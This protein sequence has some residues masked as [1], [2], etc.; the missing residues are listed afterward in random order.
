MGRIVPGRGLRPEYRGLPKGGIARL[1][2]ETGVDVKLPP[3]EVLEVCYTGDTCA[4]GIALSPP[5]SSK[6]ANDDDDDSRRASLLRRAFL[7]PLVLCECTYLENNEINDEDARGHMRLADVETVLRSHGWGDDHDHEDQ[8]IVLFH[9]SARWSP[10]VRTLDAIAAG[11]PRD[12]RERTEVS[13]ASLLSSSSS[14]DEEKDGTQT[15]GSIA[16]RLTKENGC[17]SVAEY[18]RELERNRLS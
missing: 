8:T 15:K 7:A 5:P 4:E 17:V 18:V 1:V 16:K 10:A 3:A 11:L 2:R 13:V 9:V 12:L 14:S 6:T